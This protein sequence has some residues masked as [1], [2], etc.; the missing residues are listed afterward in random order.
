MDG[1]S[2]PFDLSTQSGGRYVVARI[3]DPNITLVPGNHTYTI[4]YRVDGVLEPGTDGARDAVLLEPD[5]RRLGPA[6]RRSPS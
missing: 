3:G 6:D 1:A 2:E 5:P 4:S